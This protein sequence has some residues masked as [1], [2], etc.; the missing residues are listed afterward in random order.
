MKKRKVF[1]FF[2]VVGTVLMTTFS[3]YI[4]Q[5]I[6]T[7]N[8]LVDREDRILFIQTDADFRMVQ[9]TMYKYKYVYD[10]VS[11]SFVARLMDYDE[12]VKPGRYRLKR[13]MSNVE[14]VRLLRAG[15]QEP[16]FITFNN[17]RLKEELARK[18]TKNIE[19]KPND[20]LISL[21]N[22]EN[23]N[24]RGF[25]S[26]T[27]MC[28]FIPNTYEVY[29]NLSSEA[30]IKRIEEEYD[31]FWNDERKRKAD[32]IGL[33]TVEISILASIVQAEASKI[34]EGPIIAGL[35]QNR[36]QNGM[37]L[38]AD[39]TLVYAAG[40]FTIKRVLNI[41]KE[42]DSPYN[43][44]MYKGLPPGPINLPEIWAIDAVLNYSQHNYIYMCA[45]ED[46]SGYHNFA[47]NLRE[48]NRNAAKYQQALSREQRKARQQN[49]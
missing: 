7:P 16:A 45:R 42:I 41:H 22:F 5:I 8:I 29:W 28:L 1:A 33:S 6:R 43:T 40:D 18:I 46:F 21:Q 49:N 23:K 25:N 34:E 38:Q 27:D 37:F 44:Y 12:A 32:S 14:A 24:D 39:P 31:R 19:M 48:H 36:L 13:D 20:F 17:V 47:T 35:Y 3:F 26:E 4:Y 10:M 15:I 11:F 2:L 30:L 9:D